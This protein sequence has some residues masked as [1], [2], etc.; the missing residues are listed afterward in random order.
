M[1]YTITS[2]ERMKDTQLHMQNFTR[3]PYCLIIYFW[4]SNKKFLSNQ[5]HKNRLSE[6]EICEILYLYSSKPQN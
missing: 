4:A 1:T 5:G 6:F 2:Y 3:I